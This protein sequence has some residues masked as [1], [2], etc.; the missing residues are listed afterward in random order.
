MFLISPQGG[1]D[2]PITCLKLLVPVLD[3]TVPSTLIFG[4][5]PFLLNLRETEKNKIE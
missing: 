1:G 4:P 3:F 5:L 2:V